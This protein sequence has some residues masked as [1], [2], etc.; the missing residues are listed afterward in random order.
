MDPVQQQQ[1]MAHMVLAMMPVFLLVGLV[2]MAFF[3]FLFWRIFTKAGLSGPLSLIVLFPGI[4]PLIVLC[5][6]AFSDWKVVPVPQQVYYTPPSPAYPTSTPP[7][8]L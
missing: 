4:G 7:T 5:I 8:T 6:L 3:V 1:Q 2:F